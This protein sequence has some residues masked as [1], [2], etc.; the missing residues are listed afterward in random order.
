MLFVYNAILQQENQMNVKLPCKKPVLK[1]PLKNWATLKVKFVVDQNFTI[2]HSSIFVTMRLRTGM[3]IN[4]S[5][6]NAFK[7]KQLNSR[8]VEQLTNYK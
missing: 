8:H 7:N 5:S 4:L 1:L 2:M 6:Q 3:Q